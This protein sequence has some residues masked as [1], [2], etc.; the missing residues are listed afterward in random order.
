MQIS[1]KQLDGERCIMQTNSKHKKAG[2][3]MLI[4][5]KINFKAKSNARDTEGDLIMIKGTIYRRS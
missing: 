4:W 5:D 3:A 2:V 1:W